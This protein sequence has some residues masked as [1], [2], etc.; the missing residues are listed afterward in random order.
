[1][2]P[3]W[4]DA[5]IDLSRANLGLETLDIYYLH[6][7]ESQLAAVSRD[8]FQRAHPQRLRIARAQSRRPPHSL[9]RRR[10]LERISRRSRPIARIC[11]CSRWL[12]AATDGRRQ[13]S[14]FPR[15]PIALQSRDA[16]GVHRE[17]SATAR[18]LRRQHA[19]RRRRVR[20]GG[21]RERLAA[22]GAADPR[23]AGAS[24]PKP[25]PA[26]TPTLSAPAIRT[27][28]AGRQCRAGRDE[29]CRSR[30]PQS[31][32]RAA[33]PASFDALMKLFKRAE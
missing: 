17:E 11:R 23:D 31:G 14:S 12:K 16:R 29:F 5:M 30:N 19:G 21:M 10:D 6:N 13:G 3:R 4:L 18:R 32:D 25:S 2:T 28:D 27:L 15:D 8:E 20:Y 1:M 33:S 7:P 26:S 22:A 24:W 9:V